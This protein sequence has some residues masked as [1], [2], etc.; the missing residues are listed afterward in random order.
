M[1]F[2]VCKG[3]SIDD[4]GDGVEGHRISGDT[5][6]MEPVSKPAISLKKSWGGSY[7]RT[8]HIDRHTSYGGR[9]YYRSDPAEWGAVFRGGKGFL[10]F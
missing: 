10:T 1:Y 3:L 5:T 8:T 9:S 7:R 6:W 2:L 4:V